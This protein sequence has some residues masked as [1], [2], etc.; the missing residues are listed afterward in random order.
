MKNTSRTI[1]QFVETAKRLR[2]QVFKDDVAFLT[3]LVSGEQ[4]TDL[5]QGA[6]T[7]FEQLLKHYD[8]TDV[9]R[10]TSF[11][12]ALNLLGKE[13]NSSL[14]VDGIIAAARVQDLP[15]RRDVV[16]ALTG[17]ATEH[18]HPPSQQETGRIVQQIAPVERTPRVLGRIIAKEQLEEENRALRARVKELERENKELRAEVSKL[19]GKRKA[20]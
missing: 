9:S 18:G 14:G 20:A 4:Q 3:H 19:K 13:V 12:N 10:Y 1:E 7:S 6:Y 17:F 8:L 11:R 16:R 2:E 5:W 15:K